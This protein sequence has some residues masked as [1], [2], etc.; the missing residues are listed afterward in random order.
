MNVKIGLTAQQREVMKELADREDRGWGAQ[1]A[2]DFR[3]FDTSNPWSSR[4]RMMT[5]NSARQVLE[6]LSKRKDPLVRVVAERPRTY[7]LTEAGREVI[8]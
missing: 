4:K 1:T 5:A 6:R 8:S 3:G 7:L 2:D